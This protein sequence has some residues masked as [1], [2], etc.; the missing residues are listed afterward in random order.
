MQGR[1]RRQTKA[2]S[3]GAAVAALLLPLP[4][5]AQFTPPRIVQIINSSDWGVPDLPQRQRLYAINKGSE[6]NIQ[7][8]DIVN[9]YREKRFIYETTSPL[10]IFLGIITI[11]ES[12]DGASVGRFTLNDA[13]LEDPIVRVKVAMKGDFL[14][15]RLTLDSSLL[16]DQ[17]SAELKPGIL[18]EFK[19]VA[20][21]ILYHKPSKL[22]IEGH[23]DADGDEIYNTDLSLR[24]AEAVRQTLIAEYDFIRPAM[25]EARGYGEERPLADNDTDMNKALNRRIE[26]VVWW[27]DLVERVET[28]EEDEEKEQLP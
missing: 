26:V 5:V 1:C 11:T 14:V 12:H 23:T 17:G 25:L 16:F 3:V 27:E 20:D 24:R 8:G 4:S 28:S 10:R 2:I 7:K 18:A 21:F 19:N 9:V 15:P 13:I 6:S 22:I